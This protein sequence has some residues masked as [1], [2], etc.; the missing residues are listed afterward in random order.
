MKEYEAEAR[1]KAILDAK[2][3]AEAYAGVLGQ[4][5]GKALMIAEQ[6]TSSPQPQPMYKMAVAESMDSGRNT[7][8]PGEITVTANI[9]V[10]FALID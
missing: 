8:A 4:S 9:Q 6:G 3:K 5:I 10:S 2:Q 1:K 7:I